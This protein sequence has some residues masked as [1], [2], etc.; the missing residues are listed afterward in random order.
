[1]FCDVLTEVK[2]KDITYFLCHVSQFSHIL[3]LTDFR[4]KKKRKKWRKLPYSKRWK[5]HLN[6][7]K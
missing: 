3:S 6:K 4:P 7:P 5:A 1:M 2:H